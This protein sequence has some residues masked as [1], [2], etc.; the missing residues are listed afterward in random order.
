MIP[1]VRVCATSPAY[2]FVL[3]SFNKTRNLDNSHLRM[4]WFLSCSTTEDTRCSLDFTTRRHLA[5]KQAD[6][7]ARQHHIRR[8]LNYII[9]DAP[10][11]PI[12]WNR[13]TVVTTAPPYSEY[14]NTFR[15]MCTRATNRSTITTEPYSNRSPHSTHFNPQTPAP[16]AK[17]QKGPQPQ[18]HV[19]HRKIHPTGP[20]AKPSASSRP[21]TPYLQRNALSRP[22]F[23]GSACDRLRT[24]PVPRVIYTANGN[25]RLCRA[26]RSASKVP[27]KKMDVR[28]CRVPP[29]A[30]EVRKGIPG[31]IG[32]VGLDG[33]VVSQY[34]GP[35]SGPCVLL[36]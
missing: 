16:P 10:A 33:C 31:R 13:T 11:L 22:N 1:V 6:T 30:A 34:G 12:V 20:Q 17:K 18:R 28:L 32:W 15:D 29:E 26:N 24:V 19:L 36:R 21:A 23:H 8:T 4:T 35:M 3:T 2:S 5:S 27:R 9:T 25:M 7:L 14:A